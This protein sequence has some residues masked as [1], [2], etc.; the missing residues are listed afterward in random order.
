MN[1]TGLA[2]R[3]ISIRIDRPVEE[4]YA[5][6]SDP[7]H[8]PA[9]AQGLG[10]AIEKIGDQWVAASSPMGRVVV[11]FAPLNDFGVLDHHVTLPSGMTVYNPVRVISNEAGSEVV[12]TLR[13]Q[14]QMSDAD[15]ERD[16]GMVADDLARLRTL[17]ES[18]S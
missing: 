17:M 5:Y 18:K 15:F 10:G 3:H 13:R 12:F 1:S 7:A 14:A 16:A 2:S 6:A 11:S 8:L 4:V 9:W